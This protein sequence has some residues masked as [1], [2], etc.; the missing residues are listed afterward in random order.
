MYLPKGYMDHKESMRK[1]EHL[2]VKEA[3]MR[4]TRQLNLRL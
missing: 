1:F 3:D 2:P 4:T